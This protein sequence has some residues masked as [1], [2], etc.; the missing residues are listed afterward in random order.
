M[1]IKNKVHSINFKTL[2]Y[3]VLF[4]ISILILL[5]VFQSLFLNIFYEKYQI[6]SLDKIA[7]SIVLNNRHDIESV[8]NDMKFDN[9][10]CIEFVDTL[11]YSTIFNERATGCLL[12]D[13]SLTQYKEDMLKS[14]DQINKIKLINP[15]YDTQ[16]L[17]Y[18]I[19][20][21]FGQV[22][23][24]TM[25]E[26]VEE[27]SILIRSQ[28][29]YVMIIAFL[30]AIMISWFLSKKLCEPIVDITNDAKKLASGNYDIKFNKNGILEIDELADTLNYLEDE[31]VKIDQYRRDLMANV[32]HDLKTPLTMIKAYAEMVRDISYKDEVKMKQNLSVIIDEVDRLNILVNDILELSKL[33]ANK[34]E[35]NIDEFDLVEEINLILK[36]YDLV[37]ETE[38][39]CFITEMPDKALVRADKKRI[40]QVLYN[41]INNA[42]NYTGDDKTVFIKILYDKKNYI[43]K[44]IDTGKG[45]SSKDIDHIWDKYYKEE[46]NH[47][48]NVIGTGLG[49]S[50]VK[51]ILNKHN[52]KYGVKSVKNKGSEFYFKIKKAQKK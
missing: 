36:R 2:S 40:Q 37:K 48:R 8:I 44:I 49:L 41:L 32:S 31:L 9:N 39:Y 12:G 33:Q 21:D 20:I 1:N 14:N 35:L 25:L 45:I 16:S 5:Y 13:D 50:I 27:S 43:V 26:D 38:D 23:V 10:I 34:D 30:F 29:M 7:N 19:K 3:L 52:F 46:K 22:Y 4:S 11:G 47:K 17:L 6:K 28:L 42:I 15:Y 18:G 24:Y 51:N